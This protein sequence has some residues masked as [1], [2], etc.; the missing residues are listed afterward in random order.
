MNF[1]FIS[2]LVELYSLKLSLL[3][4]SHVI[5]KIFLKE[6][7]FLSHFNEKLKLRKVSNFCMIIA[8]Q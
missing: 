4:L 3:T 6:L 1:I 8:S 5:L 2:M 7:L